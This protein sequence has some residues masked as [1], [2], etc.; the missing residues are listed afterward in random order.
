MKHLF[1]FFFILGTFSFVSAQSYSFPKSWEG[2]WEGENTIYS[3]EITHVVPFSIEIR[4]INN[5]RWTWILY[6]KAEGQ[7][8]RKYELVKDATGWMID[9]KN[10]IVLPLSLMGNRFVSSFSVAN[11]LIVCSYW[12]ENNALNMEIYSMTQSSDKQTGLNTPESPE[13]GIHN[14][15]QFQKAILYRKQD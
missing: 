6:Y 1:F 10:G 8:P 14:L 2:N 15:G 5:E 4:P 13:V 9:E 11:N 3:A 7:K 12:L